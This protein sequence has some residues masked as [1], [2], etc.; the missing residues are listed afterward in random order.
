[1]MVAK[2]FKMKLTEYLINQRWRRNSLIIKINYKRINHIVK[3]KWLKYKLWYGNIIF[4]HCLKTSLNMF[5]QTV[6]TRIDLEIENI[7]S[8]ND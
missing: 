4:Q 1:V 6:T 7:Q 3:M 2:N 5:W 8:M